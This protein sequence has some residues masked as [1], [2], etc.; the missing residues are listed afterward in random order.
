MNHIYLG[1]NFPAPR[2]YERIRVE[3]VNFN[4]TISSIVEKFREITG[5]HKDEISLAYCGNILEDNEPINRYLRTGSTIHVLR[6]NIEDEPKDYNKF[7]ELD[8][9][10]VCSMFRSLNSGNFHVR[11]KLFGN[12]QIVYVFFNDS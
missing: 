4:E 9:S 6:K 8:V 5:N 1:I 7:T 11:A 12:C 2:N 3:N 10:R